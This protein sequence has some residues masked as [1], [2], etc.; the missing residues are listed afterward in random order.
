MCLC[1]I[2]IGQ[3]RYNMVACI[4]Y[5]KPTTNSAYK[6]YGWCNKGLKSIDITVEIVTDQTDI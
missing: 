4:V 1:E 6:D 2:I 5:T 3:G